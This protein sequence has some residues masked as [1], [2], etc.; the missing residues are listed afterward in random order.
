M[1][2]L[3]PTRRIVLGSSKLLPHLASMRQLLTHPLTQSLH[4]S[5]DGRSLW[6]VGG[7]DH[8]ED[9]RDSHSQGPRR[10]CDTCSDSVAA[11]DDG[12]K[13]RTGFQRAGQ[14]MAIH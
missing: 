8:A 11:D 9:A 10:S 2:K 13:S 4:R 5:G 14:R 6:C 12:G 3:E 1:S 7:L